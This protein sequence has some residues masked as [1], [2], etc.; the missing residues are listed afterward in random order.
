MY[1]ELV[2]FISFVMNNFWLIDWLIAQFWK[3]AKNTLQ[4]MKCE[5]C[6]TFKTRLAIFQHYAWQG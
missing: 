1:L 4:I 6:K 3:M 5:H 2:G